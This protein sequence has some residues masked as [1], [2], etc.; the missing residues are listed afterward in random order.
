MEGEGEG[1]VVVRR[2]QFDEHDEHGE[3]MGGLSMGGKRFV[4]QTGM[5]AEGVDRHMYVLPPIQV[6]ISW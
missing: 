3:P 6:D 5:S 2:E 4:T 1:A